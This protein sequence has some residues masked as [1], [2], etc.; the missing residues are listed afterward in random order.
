[1]NSYK[2]MMSTIQHEKTD[3]VPVWF[4]IIQHTIQLYNITHKE[5]SSNPHKMVECQIASL[6]R[7]GYDGIFISSDNKII[8]EA[9]G[10]EVFLPE[11]E[12]PQF[13]SK[14]LNNT[15]DLSKLE[16]VNPLISGRMP[17]IIEATKLAREELKDK[18][19]IKTCCDSAPFQAAGVLRGEEK[20]MIDLY[21]D[22]QFVFDLLEVC[23]N[24]IIQFGRA[25]ASSGAHALTFGDATA[26]LISR[27]LYEKFAFPF[28]K[29]V[30]NELKKTGIPVFLHVC[31]DTIHIL[32]LLIDS[33]A[34]VLEIDSKLDLSYA[35]K[36]AGTKVALEGNVD[37]V[38]G[39][40]WGTPEQVYIASIKCI[41]D[42][43]RNSGFILSA[44][45]EV[46]RDTPSENIDSMVRAA[47]DYLI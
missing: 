34:D 8:A 21:E 44:G 42:A 39:L 16:K 14:I 47:R 22:E 13:K 26:S 43:G 23:S 6:N 28:S 15:K 17:Q 5:Y 19:F 36:M 45:C 46:P 12:P 10:D 18:Y 27:S 41:N 11:D 7:Y 40:L 9:F 1:M 37:P 2:R 32:D 25:I 33:G 31:G 3:R 24:A 29:Y 38:D 30:I 20:L 35:K 4:D